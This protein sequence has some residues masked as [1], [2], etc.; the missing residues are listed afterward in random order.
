MYKLKYVNF[1]I[2][3]NFIQVL[4]SAVQVLS[5]SGASAET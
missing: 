3:P 2:L 4:V 1:Y 5:I